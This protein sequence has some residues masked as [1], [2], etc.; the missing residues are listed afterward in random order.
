MSSSWEEHNDQC[1]AWTPDTCQADDADG[2]K[3]HAFEKLMGDK[4]A[5]DV[6]PS[7]QT[8]RRFLLWTILHG[9]FIL[10]TN[11]TGRG[12]RSELILTNMGPKTK[13]T[14]GDS[15]TSWLPAESCS[16]KIVCEDW[17]FWIRRNCFYFARYWTW[18]QDREMSAVLSVQPSTET[19]LSFRKFRQDWGIDSMISIEFKIY[20]SKNNKCGCV[21]SNSLWRHFC[22][23]KKLCEA[24]RSCDWW[25]NSMRIGRQLWVLHLN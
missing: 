25:E 16:V 17:K 20:A 5:C 9:G 13:Q 18:Q 1:F 11:F 4:P 8:H 7:G 22:T 3:R 19:F 23:R 14:K 12:S 24:A 2:D 15:L 10:L 6:P 21:K